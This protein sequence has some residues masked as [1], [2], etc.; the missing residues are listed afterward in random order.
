MSVLDHLDE[1]RRRIIIALL[2]LVAVFLLGFGVVFE[3]PAFILLLSALGVV[4]TKRL[5]R[6]RKYALLVLYELGIGLGRL[7]ERRRKKRR[8][9]ELLT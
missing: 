9:Q 3:M 8:S 1:L 2:A 7:A 4:S 5:R 6:W